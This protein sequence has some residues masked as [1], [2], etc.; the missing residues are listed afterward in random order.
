M[1]FC[2]F[3]GF[4]PALPQLLLRVLFYSNV[5]SL[6]STSWLYIDIG[7]RIKAYFII[8]KSAA[9]RRS[10]TFLDYCPKFAH[11]TRYSRFQSFYSN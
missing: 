5:I 6:I 9:A 1:V 11:K 4:L 7:N 3:L 10:P 2:Y 8:E